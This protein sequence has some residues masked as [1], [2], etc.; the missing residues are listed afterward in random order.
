[1]LLPVLG[2]AREQ[3]KRA[4]CTSNLRQLSIASMLYSEE[5]EDFRYLGAVVAELDTRQPQ[6]LVFVQGLGH[7]YASGMVNDGRVFFCPSQN[8]AGFCYD[9]YVP[10]L[11]PVDP[12]PSAGE[13]GG[14]ESNA[15][16]AGHDVDDVLPV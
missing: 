16:V 14:A 15:E 1:M 5:N 8:D 11:T 10:W 2:W 7:L 12:R 4:V 3:G 6:Y 13:R 9:K